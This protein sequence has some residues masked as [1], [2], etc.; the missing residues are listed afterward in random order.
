MF[1]FLS[2]YDW[3]VQYTEKKDES[4]GAKTVHLSDSELHIYDWIRVINMELDII[5]GINKS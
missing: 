3:S 1:F 4:M 2:V 5:T